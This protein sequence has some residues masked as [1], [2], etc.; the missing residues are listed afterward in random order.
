MQKAAPGKDPEEEQ[1]MAD[2]V[3]IEQEVRVVGVNEGS[4][5]FVRVHALLPND[6][7]PGQSASRGRAVVHDVDDCAH[8]LDEVQR[9]AD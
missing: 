4:S 2:C 7:R 6:T 8:S 3:R 9:Q 5:D 1:G